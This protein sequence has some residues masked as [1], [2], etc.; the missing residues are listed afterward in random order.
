MAH[1]EI[2][3]T[4]LCP[5]C[6]QARWLLH[7]KKVAVTKI[8]IRMYLGVKLPTRAYRQMVERSGGDR[9]VPQIFVNGQYL[10]TEEQLAQLEAAGQLDAI[11][12]GNLP[13]PSPR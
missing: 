2:Y 12:A 3:S 6:W 1:I 13:P 8:P 5:Y 11:L 7:R 4:P 9:T 10:G